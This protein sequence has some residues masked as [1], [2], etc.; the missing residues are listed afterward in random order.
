M[1]TETLGIYIIPDSGAE[2]PQFSTEGSA[3]FDICARL[4]KPTIAYGPQNVQVEIDGTDGFVD[5][6]SG[7]RVLVPTGI[8]LDIPQGF[9]VRLHSRS[10]LALKEGLILANAEGVIDSDYTQEL[11][12]M[13]TPI[14]GSIVT[15]NDGMRICQG[16]LVRNQ[17]VAFTRNEFPPQQKTDRVGGFGSTGV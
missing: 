4:H 3:C 2:L 1:N 8:I 12:V 6:P 14:N 10:G 16:E 5:I 11:M 17:P 9:S 15:I 13:V 7:W